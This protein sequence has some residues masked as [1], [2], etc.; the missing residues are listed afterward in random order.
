MSFVKNIEQFFSNLWSQYIKPEVNNAETVALAF[1]SAGIKDAEAILGAAGLKIVSDAVVAA[2]TT[3][4]SPGAKFEAA[5]SA[6]ET[7]LKSIAVTAPDHVLNYAIEGAVSQMNAASPVVSDQAPAEPSP[8]VQPVSGSTAPSVPV[9]P[10]MLHNAAVNVQNGHDVN[11]EAA[12]LVID[13]QGRGSVVAFA[14]ALMQLKEALLTLP[15]PPS[16]GR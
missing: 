3:G 6:I 4:G 1:F 2:E 13:M 12:N 5:K 8:A 16:N 15:P 14:D 7:D 11:A 9:T 10:D